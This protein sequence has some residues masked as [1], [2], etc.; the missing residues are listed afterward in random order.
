MDLGLTASLILNVALL[1]VIFG[2]SK[3]IKV[4]RKENQKSLPNKSN[5][6]LI[7]VASGKLKS[8]GD[9][10]TIKYLREEKGMSMLEAKQFVDTLKE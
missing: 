1:I 5:D 2:Q 9:I 10:K 3:E 7:A 4:L 6:E 8:I